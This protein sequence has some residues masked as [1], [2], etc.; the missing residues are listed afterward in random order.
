MSRR[1]GSRRS[2]R[3]TG[4]HPTGITASPQRSPRAVSAKG[5]PVAGRANTLVFP[6]LSSGNIGYKLVERLG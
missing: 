1:L 2:R 5:S 6:D 3:N 4:S